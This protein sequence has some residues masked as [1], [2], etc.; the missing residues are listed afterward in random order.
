MNALTEGKIPMFSV[1]SIFLKAAIRDEP[2]LDGQD[3][4]DLA[5]ADLE[6]MMEAMTYIIQGDS[7]SSED[8]KKQD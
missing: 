6:G 5:A 2:D 8:E 4:A 3:A 7:G 1:Q